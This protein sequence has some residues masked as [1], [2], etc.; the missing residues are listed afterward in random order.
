M[1]Y[2]IGDLLKD[3]DGKNGVVVIQWDDGDICSLENDAAHPGPV[4]VG[5]VN[6]PA[7]A[8][9]MAWIKGM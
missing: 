1:K 2:S 7:K 9:V 5:H 4:I 8:E 6:I 3:E